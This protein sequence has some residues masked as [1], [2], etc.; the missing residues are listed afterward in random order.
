MRILFFLIL[1]PSILFAQSQLET[2]EQLFDQNQFE[3]A[4]QLLVPYVASHPKDLKG[5]ELLGDAYSN[6]KKWDDAQ[7]CYKK[8]IEFEPDNANYHYKYGGVLGLK[9][10]SANKLSALSMIGDVKSSF[11]KAAELDPKHIGVRWALVELYMRMPGI[12]GGSKSKSLK[13]ADELEKL[14]PV[15]GYL[16]K[17]YIYETDDEPDQA[18][19]YYKKAVQVG[20]S[21]I[22]YNKLT[23]FYENQK[24]P[25]KAIATIEATQK[26]HENIFFSYQ[27]G[28]MAAEFNVELDK[29]E[30][31]LMVF[32]EKCSDKDATPKAWAHYRLAQIYKYKGK[33]SEALKYID[34]AMNELPKNK[35]FEDEK[36]QILNLN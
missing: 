23:T 18:E 7:G 33:K 20:G 3:K 27:I 22:C 13:Y 34:L 5:L 19:N 29:G 2:A 24:Q 12:V 6:Q 25:L 17:G 16:A 15:D 32:L 30:Q 14:S 9:A 10:Q 21:A 36:E 31:Q 11:L 26:K 8:L 1:L 4:Q 28:K 35:P